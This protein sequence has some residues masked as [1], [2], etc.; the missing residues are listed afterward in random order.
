MIKQ[1]LV[2]VSK[3]ETIIQ[4]VRIVGDIAVVVSDCKLEVIVNNEKLSDHLVY[5]RIWQK[6]NDIWRLVGGQATPVV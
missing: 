4:N 6:F 2:K 3:I 5:T 1:G